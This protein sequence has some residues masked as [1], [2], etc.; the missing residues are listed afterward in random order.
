MTQDTEERL[1]ALIGSIYD[2]ALDPSL[3][4]GALMGVRQFVG[5][6]AATLDFKDVANKSVNVFYQDGGVDPAYIR[7][8]NEKYG[9]QDPFSVG[10]YF[11]EIGKPLSTADFMPYDEFTQTRV[12]RE[13]IQPSGLVDCITTALDKS[14]TGVA[15]VSVFRHERDGVVDDE[16]RR[17]MQMI[18]PHIQRAVLIGR[19]IDFKSAETATLADATDSLSAGMLLVDMNGRIVHANAAAHVLL[20]TGDILRVSNGRLAAGDADADRM[21]HEVFAA[22]EGGDAALGV[23]GIAVPLTARDGEHYVAHVLPMT[24]G[25]RRLA[26]KAYAA[27]VALF[28]HKAAL[29]MPSP[30]ETI[31]KTFRLTP[32]ELRVL[33]AVV[34]VGGV[35]DV[36]EA[37]GVAETTVKTHLGRLYEKTGTR[38]QADLVKLVAGFS[39]PLVS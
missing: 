1:S 38:R 17:R 11:A 29:N 18:V 30:P 19:V 35:P 4:P 32:T 31:A 26:G 13:F 33:L 9:K 25:K 16:T 28:V 5:G 15:M 27:V 24:E 23:K 20:A 7:L 36:A 8:Y 34:E 14:A 6:S 21:L 39:S 3:W 37:L 12:Y 2:A 22:A 10:H